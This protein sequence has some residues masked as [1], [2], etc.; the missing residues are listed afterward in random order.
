MRQQEKI[1]VWP[2]YFDLTKTRKD[3][4]RVAKSMSIPSPRVLEL[5]EAADRVGLANELVADAGYPKTPW[6]KTGMLKVKKK[7]SKEQTVKM[8]AKELVK[9][10]AG[11]A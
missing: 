4:R 5:K 9:M 1:L 2:A 7:G 11:S 8:I 6:M 10:R 3:G